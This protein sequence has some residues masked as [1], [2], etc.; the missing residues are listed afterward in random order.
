[1][2][3]QNLENAKRAGAYSAWNP[4]WAKF[5]EQHL[6]AWMHAENGLALHVFTAMQRSGP[7]NMINTA[8]AVNS[9]HKLRF[10]QDLALY[11]LDLSESDA[12]AFDGSTHKETW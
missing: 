1:Q 9:A 2:V 6:G 4:A 5:V 7:T 10:A 11:N 12:L 3:Q 8:I